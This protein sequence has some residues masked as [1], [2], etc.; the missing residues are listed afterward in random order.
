MRTTN[1]IVSER[2]NVTQLFPSDMQT[3]LT[4]GHFIQACIPRYLSPQHLS[5]RSHQDKAVAE[6]VICPIQEDSELIGEL[7]VTRSPAHSFAE[8]EVSLIQQVANQCAAALHQARLYQ[9]LQD[10]LQQLKKLN[11]HKNNSMLSSVQDLDRF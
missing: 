4:S 10:Q 2:T 9:N 1:A 6:V 3:Q 11:E 5:Y 7:W 8:D